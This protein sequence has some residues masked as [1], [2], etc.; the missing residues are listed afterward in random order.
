MYQVIKRDG[1]SVAFN[2]KKIADAIEKAVETVLSKGLRTPDIAAEGCQ[3]IG[4]AAMGDAVAAA[5]A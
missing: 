1:Q 4:T 3:K 2:L 5:L